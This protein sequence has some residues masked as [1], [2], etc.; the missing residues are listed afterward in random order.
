MCIVQLYGYAADA[1]WGHRGRPD[2]QHCQATYRLGKGWRVTKGASDGTAHLSPGTLSYTAP[3]SPGTETIKLS[4]GTAV[5]KVAD[6]WLRL[7]SLG[8]PPAPPGPVVRAMGDSV[9][10]RVLLCSQAEN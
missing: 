5:V 8:G 9:T 1:E 7:G 3:D 4:H 6:P 2:Q 10:E